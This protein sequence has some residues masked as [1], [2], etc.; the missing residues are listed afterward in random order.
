[1]SFIEF[2]GFAYSI[3]P[4]AISFGFPNIRS[5]QGR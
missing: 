3:A 5:L 2:F 1:L 4:K